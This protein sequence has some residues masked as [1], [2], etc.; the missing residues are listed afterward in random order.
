[1]SEDVK[2]MIYYELNGRVEHTEI[3]TADQLE[4]KAAELELLGAVDLAF[5]RAEDV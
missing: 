1:M 5:M 4:A 2:F 3:L